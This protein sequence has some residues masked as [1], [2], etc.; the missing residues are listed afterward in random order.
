MMI[1]YDILILKVH[2][3]VYFLPIFVCFF[4]LEIT[5]QGSD[6]ITLQGQIKGIQLMVLVVNQ[7]P[8]NGTLISTT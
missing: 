3:E 4:F 1:L 6:I 8:V 2:G 5:V 7:I